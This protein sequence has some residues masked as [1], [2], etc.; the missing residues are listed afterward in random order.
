LVAASAGFALAA[1]RVKEPEVPDVS[2]PILNLKTRQ[3]VLAPHALGGIIRIARIDAVEIVSKFPDPGFEFGPAEAVRVDSRTVLVKV[4]GT[5][6]GNPQST[7]REF[8]A[9]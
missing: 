2:E 5:H 7:W 4:D 8:T 1:F 3:T 6:S 9:L